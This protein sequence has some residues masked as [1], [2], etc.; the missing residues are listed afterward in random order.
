MTRT[1]LLAWSD[2]CTLF[3]KL[4]EFQY[5]FFGFKEMLGKLFE[6]LNSNCFGKKQ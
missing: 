6:Q 2:A 5:C 3:Q 4:S 1:N